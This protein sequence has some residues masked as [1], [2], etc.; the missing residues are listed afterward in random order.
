MSH[1]F[2]TENRVKFY[3]QTP[4]E[5]RYSQPYLVLCVAD[6]FLWAEGSGGLAILGHVPSMNNF[7]DKE[8]HKRSL[9][10]WIVVPV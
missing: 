8:R 7:I 9:S 2:R 5:S 10:N 6:D 3:L 4:H 1:Y